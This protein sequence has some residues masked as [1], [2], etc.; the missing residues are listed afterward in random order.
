L[1]LGVVSWGAL[2]LIQVPGASAA[3]V[4]TSPPVI[5]GTLEPESTLTATTGT[6]TDA[7]SPIVSYA[8]QWLRCIQ[9]ECTDIDYANASDYTLPWDLSGA[10][11]EV[12]VIATDA[13]G[14]SAPA[15]SAMT[16]VVGYD[17][18]RYI[19][20]ES[21]VGAG[22]LTGFV[23]WHAAGRAAE[24][25]LSCPGACGGGYP[26]VPGTEVELVAT[27]APGSA[28]L[29]WGGD[30]CSGSATTCSLTM[31][32]DESVTAT[33]TGQAPSAPVLPLEYEG[34]A[35]EWQPPPAGAPALGGWEPPAPSAAGLAARLLGVRYARR[36]VQ[37]EVECEQASPCHLSLAI[38]AGAP[39]AQ[40]IIARRS[41]T[42]PAERSAR[43]SLALDRAG[44]R[45]LARRHRLPVTARLALG[46]AGRASIIEQGRFTLAG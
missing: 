4:S 9:Y 21:A 42:V 5:S 46:G 31:S 36:H 27:P 43:I 11:V 44:A 34:A 16:D 1:L 19:L 10:Q 2:L 33:F 26:F 38:L 22:S 30:A 45:I 18:P 37:A 25:L 23:S 7:T 24:P 12:A 29:G 13:E 28:F 40:A 35:G 32:G 17:G 6:W 20:G 8:Y 39:G 14:E 15:T 41:F 3:P